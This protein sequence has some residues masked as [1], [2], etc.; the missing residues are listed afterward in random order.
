MKK[1]LL[2]GATILMVSSVAFA[3]GLLTNTNQHVSFLR[4]PARGAST[5]IDALYSNP[6]GIVFMNDGFHVS[7]NNQSAFQT[8][9]ITSTFAPF[10]GNGGSETKKF[11]GE[12][13]APII[14]S[15]FALYKKDKWAFGAHFAVSGGGGKATFNKGLGSFESQ[16][17]LIPA[18]ITGMTS[19]MGLAPTT[20]YS[21]DIYLEGKQIIF[22]AQIGAA[23]LFTDYLSGY[24]GLRMNIVN[25]GYVGHIRD[26]Q[27]NVGGGNMV[28]L[29]QML[30]GMGMFDA[31]A[32]VADKD[33]DCEQSGWGVTPILGVDFKMAKWNVGVKYEFKTGLN[34]E[35]KTKVNT[36]GMPA[37]DNGVETPHDIP[38]LLTLGV[39][40]EIL[41]VLRASVGYHQFFDKNADM[42]GDKQKFIDHG[43]REYLGGIE[44]DI[45]RVIQISGGVQY[46]ES[47]VT[48]NYQSDMSYSLTST[49]IGFGAGFN[50]TSKLK[51]NVA[52]FWTIYNDYTKNADNYNGTG[53]SGTDVFSRTN[54]V[55]G[56]GLDYSF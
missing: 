29:H 56:I 40:Y 45:T 31:A 9:T 48:D 37:Y 16:I 33:L 32:Q 27:A 14:P 28:N 12:A 30:S 20:Q 7:L 26:I 24:A 49:S 15:V 2:I 21:A 47:G 34:I 52:Y 11:E 42:A 53:I 36:T 22:G 19:A 18:M 54:K 55:F 39:S 17:S 3:G 23:Y 41:P 44:W 25:N 10:V 50:L 51:L 6:A 1:S 8:R 5:E 46:T 4:N 35:N 38:G 13:S 43:G